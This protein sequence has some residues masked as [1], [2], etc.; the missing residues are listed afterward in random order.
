VDRRDPSGNRLSTVALMSVPIA[1]TWICERY[2]GSHSRT[3][4][5][6]VDP[7]GNVFMTGSLGGGVQFPG[8]TFKKTF[9]PTESP[10]TCS[11]KGLKTKNWR[12]QRDKVTTLLCSIDDDQIRRI[13]QFERL[14]A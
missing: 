3:H 13:Q 11:P 10:S 9:L 8:Y 6:A 14:V 1:T 2:T 7:D 4:D 12:P 5:I